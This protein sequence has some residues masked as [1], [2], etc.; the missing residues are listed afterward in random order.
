MKETSGEFKRLLVSL[1]SGGRNMSPEADMAK[2]REDAQ[3]IYDVS[4]RTVIS[5]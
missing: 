1:V 4:F 3:A 5:V 2:A